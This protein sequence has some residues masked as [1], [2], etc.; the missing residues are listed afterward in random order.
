MLHAT[1]SQR[2]VRTVQFLKQV[3]LSKLPVQI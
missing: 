3:V 1:A 2:H